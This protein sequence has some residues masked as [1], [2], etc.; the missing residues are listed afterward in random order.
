MWSI[1]RA[2][3]VDESNN[4][5]VVGSGL[6]IKLACED[7][8]GK[9]LRGGWI[10]IEVISGGAKDGRTAC[11]DEISRPGIRGE[12]LGVENDISEVSFKLS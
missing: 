6:G 3:E 10:A 12:E 4:D 7:A 5:G 8:N 11:N 2:K 9:S 1:I